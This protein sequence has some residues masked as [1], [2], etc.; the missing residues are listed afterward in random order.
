MFVSHGIGGLICA[1]IMVL[2]NSFEEKQMK[3]IQRCIRSMI[4]LN[5]P[6]DGSALGK[7][8]GLRQLHANE[9]VNTVAIGEKFR[10]VILEN[11]WIPE[12]RLVFF[13]GP[14]NTTV[15]HLETIANR[16]ID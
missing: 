14:H 15:C 13:Y 9:C 11:D 6:F 12:N 8:D 3:T 16:C 10:R 4:F 5:T 2:G 1:E 7:R